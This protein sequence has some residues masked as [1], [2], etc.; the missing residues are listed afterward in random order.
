MP[1]DPAG[2]QKPAWPCELGDMPAR[3]PARRSATDRQA[4]EGQ[5]PR[6]RPPAS[7]EK[8]QRQSPRR[9]TRRR[10]NATA[11][12]ESSHPPIADHTRTITVS[13]LTIARRARHQ[14]HRRSGTLSSGT[15]WVGGEGPAGPRWYAVEARPWKVRGGRP[16]GA[17][18]IVPRSRPAPAARRSSCIF[19]IR[20]GSICPDISDPQWRSS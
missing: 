7:D 14:R 6:P 11:P 2:Y 17:K 20:F 1:C 3:L 15:P 12:V 8:H 4:N 9:K 18:Q 19:L 16:S 13:D 10:P 5:P